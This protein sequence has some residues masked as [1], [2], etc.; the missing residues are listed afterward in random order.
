M[1]Q[2]RRYYQSGGNYFFTLVTHQRCPIFANPEKVEQLKI[3]INKVKKKYPFFLNAIV[4]L[5]D[6][7]H[8][9]WKLP[10]ND[11]D[12]STRWRLIKRYFSIQMKTAIN[13]RKEKE[14]WQR[15]F[16][17]HAIQDEEDRGKHMDY[18]HYNPVKHGLAHTP[19]DWP[20]SSFNY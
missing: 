12:F 6:H 7:L 1:S 2:Y 8:C 18:I 17:E 13:H 10:E 11:K 14:A 4:I 9:L 19:L 20:H 3:A 16:W 15:R 5:P